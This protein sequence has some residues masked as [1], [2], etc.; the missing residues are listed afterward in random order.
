MSRTKKRLLFAAFLL[1]TLLLIAFIGLRSGDFSASLEALFDIPVRY[2]LLCVL[3]T[4]G[5]IFMQGV[6]AKSALN[7]MG[8]R[9]GMGQMFA[10]SILGEFY[11]FITP[12]A[13]GGQPMQVHRMHRRGI[14]LGDATGALVAHYL[15][16]H[17]MLLISDI[18]LGAAH[19]AFA[20][21]QVGVNWPFFVV[22]FLFN[23]MLI[24]GAV[25]LSFYQR[26]IRW[27]LGKAVALMHRF[28]IGNPDRLREKTSEAADAFYKG[29]HFL[30]SHPV[31][32]VKQALF[33]LGR[34]LCM[35]SVIYF[36]Y[37]GLGLSGISYG[38]II[39][40]GCLQYTSAAYTPLPGAS[41]AQEGIFSVYFDQIFPDELLF[42][43]LLAWRFITYYLV[44]IVGFIVTTVMGMRDGREAR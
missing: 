13:T 35:M 33:G 42:S 29:M 1:L 7:A 16:Y 32:I 3:C 39:T 43:S 38:R 21:K 5:G 30:L 18:A 8:H 41:G 26:P 17:S 4:F 19:F 25:L 20:R 23:A 34:I 9:A 28:R 36:I 31:E 37:R 12:G 10:I 22:G 2:V 11:S 27:L 44:L 14:P 24:A 40:M 6:S 15:A